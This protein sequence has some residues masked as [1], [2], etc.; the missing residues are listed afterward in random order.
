[1]RKKEAKE[2]RG[3]LKA[4]T[5]PNRNTCLFGKKTKPRKDSATVAA[6]KER[7]VAEFLATKGPTKCELGASQW[8]EPDTQLWRS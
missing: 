1:M 2:V 4:L 7:L 8:L 3:V 5:K 6:E